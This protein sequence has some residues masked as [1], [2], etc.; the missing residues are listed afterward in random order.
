MTIQQVEEK[1][2]ITKK[3]IRFYEKEGLLKP[4]RGMNQ[5]RQYT[6]EEVDALLQIRLLRRLGMSIE[7]IRLVLNGSTTLANGLRWHIG[8]LDEEIQN[9]K[10]TRALCK[11]IVDEGREL[12]AL[13]TTEILGEIEEM[14]ARG[15]GI[16]GVVREL[17]ERVRRILPPTPVHIIEPKDVLA[18]PADVDE[19]MIQYAVDRQMDLTILRG[20]SFV[21]V[22]ILDGQKLWGF[23]YSTRFGR[24]LGLY[25][26]QE[27]SQYYFGSKTNMKRVRNLFKRTKK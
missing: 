3:N 1:T 4:A 8:H 21:P 12:E 15:E 25:R 19:A 2:G 11:R 9:L 7:E 5:Y 20:N 24:F 13:H 26:S 27:E 17:A 14:E 23:C 10:N 22:V 18:T 6:D 16:V